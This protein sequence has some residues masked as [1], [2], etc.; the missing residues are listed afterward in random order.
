[1][2]KSGIQT[3]FHYQ[4]LHQTPYAKR[5]NP[6]DCPNSSIASETLVRLPIYFSLKVS[7][8]QY[9]ID[10]VLNFNDFEK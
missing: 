9:I 8:Q 6:N 2:K 5:F 3:P 7:E 1:M 4:A 10:K